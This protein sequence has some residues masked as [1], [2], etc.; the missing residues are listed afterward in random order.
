ME[1]RRCE[2]HCDKVVYPAAC[3]ER[4]CPFVYSYE[5]WGSTYVGCMQKVYDVE[6]DVD[7]LNEAERRQPGFG[8]I[9]AVRRPLPMCRSEVEQTYASRAEETGCVN[10]EFG[11]LQHDEPTFRVFAR[12]TS[13]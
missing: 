12:L 13:G 8:A 6:I 5:G 3:L 10:P 1:C 2:V 7:M 11:E 9:R 4:A